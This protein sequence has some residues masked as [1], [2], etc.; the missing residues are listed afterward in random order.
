MERSKVVEK[1]EVEKE[2]FKQLEIEENKY[3]ME[4]SE[5]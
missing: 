5:Y 2:R 1:F 4:Y 3:W